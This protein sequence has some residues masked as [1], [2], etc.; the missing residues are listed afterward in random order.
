MCEKMCPI[1]SNVLLRS[2]ERG[3]PED[4]QKEGRPPLLNVGGPGSGRMDA[5]ATAVDLHT[6]HRR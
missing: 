4:G 2:G 1:V 5:A 6:N 3:A